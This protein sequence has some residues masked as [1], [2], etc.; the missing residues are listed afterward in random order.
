MNN[1]IDYFSKRASV[2][3]SSDWVNNKDILQTIL[4]CLN[5]REASFL[6]ILDLGACTL[7]GS[8]GFV[9]PKKLL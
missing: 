1:V 5:S 6:N 3:D 7:S 4:K 8:A 9:F 2:Y